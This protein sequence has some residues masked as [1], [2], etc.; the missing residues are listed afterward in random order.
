[1]NLLVTNKVSF[2]ILIT[3][4]IAPMD[5]P[6]SSSLQYTWYWRITIIYIW[7]NRCTHQ[8]I[9]YN[10]PW[11]SWYMWARYF[12]LFHRSS[13]LS[14]FIYFI[15]A[16]AQSYWHCCFIGLIGTASVPVI[17]LTLSLELALIKWNYF[18]YSTHRGYQLGGYLYRTDFGRC[19]GPSSV[20]FPSGHFRV[21]LWHSATCEHLR[22]LI[23]T[24]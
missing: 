3:N 24:L 11:P 18:H 19:Q 12:S 7:S 15:E 8:H 5:L 21:M 1:M 2:L 23:S 6:T 22:S 20:D 14:Y 16:L 17:R 9:S 10:D 13:E 4:Y